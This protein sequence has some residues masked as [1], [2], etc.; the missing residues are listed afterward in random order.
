MPVYRFIQHCKPTER[1][2]TYET[3]QTAEVILFIS[4][5]SKAEAQV[6]RMK[7]LEE[8]RWDL[9]ITREKS[10]LIEARIREVG[11]EVLSAYE[12][13][14][15]RGNWVQVFPDHFAA[16][17]DISTSR[18]PR[19]DERFV[20]RMVADAGGRRLTEEERGHDKIR[21]ADYLLLGHAVELKD[22]Q[23]EGL[24]KPERQTKLAELFSPYFPDE[25]EILIDASVLSEEDVFRY[26]DIVG[27]PLKNQ[28]KSAS[29]QIKST[30]RHLADEKLLGGIILLNSGYYTL[31]DEVFHAQAC[32]YAKKNSSHIEFVVTLTAG[33][34][35]DGFNSWLNFR[36][37]PSPQSS[38]VETVLAEAFDS[39]LGRFMTE[40]GRGGFESPEKAAPILSPV[41][42]VRDGRRFTYYP[43]G[44]PPPWTPESMRGE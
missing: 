4:A 34:S 3:W 35:T 5:P 21:N 13:T 7:V 10:T 23:E 6:L 25:D 30:K 8:Q 26:A 16:G 17:S 42:F 38:R 18:A 43:G 27:E 31:P 41:T 24:E 9:L 40:W 15:R 11:G 28:I 32:R 20:D 22:I 44:L 2:R 37:L 36:F 29:Q 12:T 39:N 33:F 19:L 14:V 1:N